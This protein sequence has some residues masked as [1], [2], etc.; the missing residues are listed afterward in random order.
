[1][2][3][4]VPSR[5]VSASRSV[6]VRGELRLGSRQLDRWRGAGL[7]ELARHRE[8]CWRDLVPEMRV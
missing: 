1:M 4:Y 8:R 3:F 6:E 5:G 7:E 2:D